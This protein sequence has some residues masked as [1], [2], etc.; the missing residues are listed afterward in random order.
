MAGAACTCAAGTLGTASSE[1]R[2]NTYKDVTTSHDIDLMPMPYISHLNQLFA[3]ETVSASH[4]NFIAIIT[5]MS[6]ARM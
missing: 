6:L 4:A 5:S 3:Y 2:S 1:T